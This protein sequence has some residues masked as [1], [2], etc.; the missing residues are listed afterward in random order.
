MTQ[1]SP[2]GHV[3]PRDLSDFAAYAPQDQSYLQAH[4]Y[5]NRMVNKREIR[6]YSVTWCA[7]RGRLIHVKSDQGWNPDPLFEEFPRDHHPG[8]PN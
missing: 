7:D 2:T 8:P 5:A 1:L 4:D 6:A 3:T